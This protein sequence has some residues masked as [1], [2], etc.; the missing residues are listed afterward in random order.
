MVREVDLFMLLQPKILWLCNFSLK[1]KIISISYNIK[2]FIMDLIQERWERC[3]IQTSNELQIPIKIVREIVSKKYAIQKIEEKKSFKIV[4]W[5]VNGIRSNVLSNNAITKGELLRLNI[6]QHSDPKTNLGSL[7]EEYQPDVVCFQETKCD[8]IT[9]N[10]IKLKNYPYQYWNSS[11]SEGARSGSRYSGTSVWSKIKPNKISYDIPTLFPKDKEGRIIIAEFDKFI[12]INLYSP[13]SGSN[14]DYRTKIWDQ[15]LKEYL[16]KLKETGKVVVVC[17]DLNV[18]HREEDVFFSDPTSSRYSKAKMKG[19]GNAAISGFTKQE[20][21]NFTE[22]LGTGY[23]DTFRYFHPEERKYT[24]WSQRIPSDRPNNK[25]MRLDYFLIDQENMG[26]VKKSE[27]LYHSGLV[28]LPAAS[29]HAAIL[30]E[31]DRNCVV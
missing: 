4:S 7:L 1:R 6:T 3:L 26:C 14:F 9:Y 11:K 27:I 8:H 22:I 20:R 12:L 18:S 10:N 2:H 16:E 29:D 30:L 21:E 31:L 5:N 28:S 24:W 23:V 19:E 15:A 13:N 17:G 25:G